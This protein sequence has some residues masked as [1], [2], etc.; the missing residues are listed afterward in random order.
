MKALIVEDNLSFAQSLQKV[1]LEEGW[2]VEISHSWGK[3]SPIIDK[4]AF[5]L[6]IIDIVLPDKQGLE[7]LEILSEKKSHN[8]T[9]IALI[10]ALCDESMITKKIPKNLKNYCIFFKKPIEETLFLNFLQKVKPLKTSS[11]E[12]SP[13]EA[14]F[15]KGIPSKPIR[16]YFPKSQTFNAKDLIPAIYLSHL[17]KF[18]G[19]FEI[20][21]DNDTSTIQFYKGHITQ[22]ISNSKKSFF[23]NLLVEHGL[24]LKE[25]VQA[26]LESKESKKSLG[27][28]LVEKELLSP[29]MLNFILKE[30][31]KIRL[32]EIL[33]YPSF[34]MNILEKD[35]EQQDHDIDFNKIDL[36]EWL[37]DSLQ[38]EL[39]HN[40]FNSFHMD[41]HAYPIQ[42]ST[43]IN[44]NLIHQ[45]QFLQDYN[46]L[47]K[48]LNTQTM[49]EIV[50]SSKKRTYTLQLLYFGFLTKSIYLEDKKE[51]SVNLKKTELILDSILEK[52]SKDL[53]SI[54]NLPW[55]SSVQ[56]VKKNYIQLTKTIHPDLLPK[57]VPEL[58]KEKCNE[59]FNKLTK[60]HDVLKNDEKRTK[61]MTS[62][63]KST[64]IDLMNK[65]EEG[66]TKIKKGEYDVATKV[67]SQIIHYDQTPSN[68]C[69]YL[70]WAK[71]KSKENDISKNQVEQMKIKRTIDSCPISLRTSPLFWYVKGLFYVQVKQYEK[72]KEL[73]KKS[74]QIKKNFTEAKKELMFT[75]QLL[76]SQLKS[77]SKNIF[78][79]FLKKSS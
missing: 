33:S 68:T 78:S 70:L 42:K 29:Y 58:L 61:Y 9:K 74:L 14:F 67:L 59:A 49:E 23:G 77:K 54:L 15:E 62:Q 38:T 52:D 43:Q 73:F 19:D 20:T 53:F 75:N 57:E 2:Q 22:L 41:L 66:L 79:L 17:K 65:Y 26:L 4:S 16:F 8:F 64:F 31:I 44:I 10:S 11:N 34:K 46:L 27:E 47:F 45:K 12:S 6:L 30:Q 55:N 28:A 5:D 51:E 36:I 72:A 35:I 32:S 50:A 69:L 48:N 71:M 25:D 3:A 1:L 24:S 40:F 21:S 18:S 63:K 7:I 13:L 56:E 37:A 76:K 60:S 39:K